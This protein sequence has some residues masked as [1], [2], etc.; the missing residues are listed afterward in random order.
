M[1]VVIKKMK[2]GQGGGQEKKKIV[3]AC[4]RERERGKDK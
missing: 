4:E 3:N 1:H 2:V